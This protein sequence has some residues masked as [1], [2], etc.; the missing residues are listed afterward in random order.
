MK[1]EQGHHKKYKTRPSKKRE[2]AV[3]KIMGSFHNPRPLL[4]QYPSANGPV[5][6]YHVST[7]PEEEQKRLYALEDRNRIKHKF[8]TVGEE[9]IIQNRR[10]NA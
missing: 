1:H 4:G 3:S 8:T 10:K 9:V 2:K 5:I 6:T 7:L